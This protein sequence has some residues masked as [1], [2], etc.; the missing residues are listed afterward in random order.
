VKIDRLSRI[1]VILMGVVSI[2]VIY[3]SDLLVV[4]TEAD[5]YRKRIAQDPDDCAAFIGLGNLYWKEGNKHLAWQMYK[6]AVKI[7]PDYPYTHF[8]LGKTIEGF[9]VVSENTGQSRAE[10][11]SATAYYV[12]M[13]HDAAQL[14]SRIKNYEM[15]AEKCKKIIDLEPDDQQARYNL[16]VCYYHHYSDWPKAK[17][18]LLKVIEIDRDTSIADSAEFFIDHISG[19]P[20]A[21]SAFDFSFILKDGKRDNPY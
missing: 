18:E 8:L 14:Y 11:V 15:A 7:K 9:D 17:K 13:L 10:K 5:I 3:Y 20:D 6:K 12:L 1:A 2:A 4:D 16:A 21:R 19:D